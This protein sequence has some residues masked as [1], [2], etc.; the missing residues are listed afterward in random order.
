M[1][2]NPEDLPEYDVYAEREVVW[3]RLGKNI[4]QLYMAKDSETAWVV[5]HEQEQDNSF[6]LEVPVEYALTVWR[7]PWDFVD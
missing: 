7:N 2:H 6:G 4:I 1:L 5:V 3:K